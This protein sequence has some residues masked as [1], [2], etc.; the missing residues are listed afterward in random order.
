MLELLSEF[1]K[2]ISLAFR[3]FGNVFAGEVL[4]LSLGCC[5]HISN[6]A[7]LMME[8]FVDSSRP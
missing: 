6:A 1:V 2:M 5:R 8:I 3:L 4:L 7:F